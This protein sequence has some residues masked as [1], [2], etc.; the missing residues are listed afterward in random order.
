M[1]LEWP[2]LLVGKSIM[3][4]SNR[5]TATG[6]AVGGVWGTTE[7]LKHREANTIKLRINTVLNGMTK[8][9]PFLGN[10]FAVIGLRV[11]FSPIFALTIV[12]QL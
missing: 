8:R 12:L 10:S 1:D 3:Y 7:G 4:Q 6:Q 2:G 9:G 5:S 11:D